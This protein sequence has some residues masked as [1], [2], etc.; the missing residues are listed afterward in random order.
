MY[1]D[2]RLV[3]GTDFQSSFTSVRDKPWIQQITAFID[4]TDKPIKTVIK[5][6]R[7]LTIVTLNR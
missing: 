2:G 1:T 5:E 7:T 3:V 4:T 6:N